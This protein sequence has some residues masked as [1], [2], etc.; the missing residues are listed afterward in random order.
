MPPV[1]VFSPG[2][3]V[4][5]D[6]Q[7]RSRRSGPALSLDD[8]LY[9]VVGEE[10]LAF[11]LVPPEHDR[12]ALVGAHGVPLRAIER[13][14]IHAK[15]APVGG[16]IPYALADFHDLKVTVEFRRAPG[17]L[18]HAQAL[19]RLSRRPCIEVFDMRTIATVEHHVAS[20]F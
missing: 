6:G 20:A 17:L 12:A 18:H 3:C 19:L 11:L 10:D 8:G 14:R 15:V 1:R 7:A 13:R 2:C 5:R 9:H 4:Y 16:E